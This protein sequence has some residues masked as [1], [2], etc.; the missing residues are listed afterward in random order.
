MTAIRKCGNGERG[1]AAR[2]RTTGACPLLALMKDQVNQ[3]KFRGIEA[4][5]LSSGRTIDYA[6]TIYLTKS[7]LFY[8]NRSNVMFE[9]VEDTVGQH[10][11]LLT[12]L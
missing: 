5:Y 11:F 7:N 4:E 2:A 1:V 8:S 6:E 3:L 10:D 9:M 12:V